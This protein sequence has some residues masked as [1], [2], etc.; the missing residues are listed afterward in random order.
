MRR[1]AD[2]GDIGGHPQ[3]CAK[4]SFTTI[5]AARPQ[6]SSTLCTTRYLSKRMQRTQ[7]KRPRKLENAMLSAGREF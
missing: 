3:A 1:Y 2:T 5:F 6:S 7:K 4:G